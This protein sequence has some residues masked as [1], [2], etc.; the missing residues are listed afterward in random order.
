MEITGKDEVASVAS[1]VKS[2]VGQ[3]RK[4]REH[5]EELVE[6]RTSDLTA[7]TAELERAN[8]DV[9]AVNAELEAFAFSVSHDLRAPL[10]SINGFSQALMEDYPDKLDEQGKDY[11]RRVRSAT[12]RM[13]TLIDDLLI[14]SR[15]TRSEMRRETV[16]LS[17]MAQPIAE[18]LQETQPERRV[19]F[20][21]APGLVARGDSRLLRQLMENLPLGAATGIFT[22]DR[23]AVSD[24]KELSANGLC[25]TLVCRLGQKCLGDVVHQI[26]NRMCVL[27]VSKEKLHQVVSIGEQVVTKQRSQA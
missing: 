4:H 12:Q 16:D 5:L 24:F 20:I 3:L 11:L 18:E 23:K 27:A 10:R 19:D 8:T 26:P 2:M 13:G 1:D 14:L 15:V 6:E 17:A 7:R 25:K 9:I 22:R 21:I